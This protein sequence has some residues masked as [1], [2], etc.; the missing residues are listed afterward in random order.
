M[1]DYHSGG[2][3]AALTNATSWIKRA[4]EIGRSE[5]IQADREAVRA[6]FDKQAD[7]VNMRMS[8][9]RT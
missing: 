2:V 8:K 3:A 7:E 9:V 1:K 6:Y 4:L 5:Q